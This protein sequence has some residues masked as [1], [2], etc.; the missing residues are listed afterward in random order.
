M[1]TSGDRVTTSD[2]RAATSSSGMITN[3]KVITSNRD[4]NP[5]KITIDMNSIT[6]ST[7]CRV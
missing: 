7:I 1:A 5:F 6:I 3:S 4:T 2:S